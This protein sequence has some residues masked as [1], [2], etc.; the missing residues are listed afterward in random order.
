MVIEELRV[1]ER[2]TDEDVVLEVR[3]ASVAFGMNRGRS[4][5]VQDVSV[6]IRREEVLAIVGESGCGKTMFASALMN[7]VQKPGVTTGDVIYHPKDD[8]PVD[9]LSLS[10]EEL[11][12]FR[13]EEIAM[14]FQ[15]GAESLNPTMTIGGHFRETIRAH[16]HD[17][18]ERME[19]ARELLESLYLDPDRVLSVYPHELSGGMQQRVIIALSLILEPEVLVMD[20]PTSAL[21]LLMQQSIISMLHELKKEYEVTIVFI[22]HDIPLIAGLA[23][24]L[25]VMYAFEFIELGDTEDVLLNAAHPYARA[26]TRTVPSLDSPTKDMHPIEGESPDPVNVPAGCSYHPRCPLADDQCERENPTLREV[27][28]DPDHA[29]ACFYWEDARDA[30]P[31][32]ISRKM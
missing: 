7:A 12:E 22:T 23:D 4:Q 25:A 20:E 26:L 17:E 31:Y 27:D 32:T 1:D 9:V 5:V 8:D 21:D 11:D 29:A 16:N 15:A 19:H 6:D 14:V 28:G 24:R 10:D 2:R 13:W 18:D 3:N 30:I